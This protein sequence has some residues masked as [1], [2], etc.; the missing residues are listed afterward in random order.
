[1]I[2]KTIHSYLGSFLILKATWFCIVKDIVQAII[3]LHSMGL[4]HID[5]HCSNVF[6]NEKF[7][8]KIIDFGKVTLIGAPITYNIENGS[9]ER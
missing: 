2:S 9:K 7:I 6:I 1:M 3:F 5:I 4:L 8:P